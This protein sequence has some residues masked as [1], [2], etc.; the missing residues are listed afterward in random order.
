MFPSVWLHGGVGGISD[1]NQR[2]HD[3]Q[4]HPHCDGHAVVIFVEHRL[5]ETDEQHAAKTKAD[6]ACQAD[7]SVYIADM[8]AVIPPADT[9]S[10]QKPRAGAVFKCCAQKARQHKN[11]HRMPAQP[12]EQQD[13]KYTADAVDGQ[14]GA[15]V[16][17]SVHKGV[18][19]YQIEQRFPQ[20]SGK[21]CGEEK[22]CI[23][24]KRTN[25]FLSHNAV[26]APPNS[27]FSRENKKMRPC[28]EYSIS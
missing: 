28:L 21:S 24:V 4:R 23:V 8:A 2:E 6:G 19:C 5:K 16:Y 17:A 20:P 13:Q 11:N 3:A 7:V 10:P 12:V 9:P 1:K 18:G 14:I 27:R 15:S 26:R 25:Y 22:Q